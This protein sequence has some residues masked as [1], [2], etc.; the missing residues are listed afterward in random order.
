MPTWLSK[1]STILQWASYIVGAILTVIG[2]NAEVKATVAMAAG[3]FNSA[4]DAA[5]AVADAGNT[6]TSGLVVFIVG[7]AIPAIAKMIA[8][9]FP[10][11]TAKPGYVAIADRSACETL[12]LTRVDQP[13]DFAKVLELLNTGVQL[14]IA[15]KVAEAKKTAKVA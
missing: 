8:Q 10:K 7:V 1:L 5:S 15:Q 14:D 11:K 12:L 2:K 4:G 9:F 3:A 6:Q 13:D